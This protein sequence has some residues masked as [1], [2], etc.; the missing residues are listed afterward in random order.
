MVNA[1][2]ATVVKVRI[3][4]DLVDVP[5]SN[6]VLYHATKSLLMHG[7][8]TRYPGY[9]ECERCRCVFENATAYT[10]HIRKYNILDCSP[11]TVC[12]GCLKER[13]GTHG[14]FCDKV[15]FSRLNRVCFLCNSKMTERTNLHRHIKTSHHDLRDTPQYVAFIE[16]DRGVASV[17]KYLES[18]PS[19]DLYDMLEIRN[20]GEDVEAIPGRIYTKIQ[21]HF[22]ARFPALS[23]G[24]APPTN[25]N[26]ADAEISHTPSGQRGCRVRI[27]SLSD[28]GS[29]IAETDDEDSGDEVTVEE[30]SRM[31][32]DL[33]KQLELMSSFSLLPENDGDGKFG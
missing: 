22:R 15:G 31:L 13:T 14:D 6:V 19:E 2:T 7:I 21:E 24:I 33:Y 12:A 10:T 23:N 17:L 30:I 25:Q 27:R 5:P 3:G 1:V 28:S 20:R 9:Q 26:G 16:V 11:L 18:Y 8:S 32:C 4:G 29:G